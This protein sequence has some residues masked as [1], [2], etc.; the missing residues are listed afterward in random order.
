MRVRGSVI[1]VVE[2]LGSY[3]HKTA[4]SNHQLLDIGPEKVAFHYKIYRDEGARKTM[5]LD[6]IEFLRRFCLHI[7]PPRFRRIRHHEI[8]S[9]FHKA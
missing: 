1:C 9:Y 7:L 5:K 8:L 4:I 6:G 3:T 2:Y